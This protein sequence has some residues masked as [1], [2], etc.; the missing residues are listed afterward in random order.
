MPFLNNTK[1]K[2]NIDPKSKH[3]QGLREGDIVR[4]QYTDSNSLIYT[5][6]V[7]MSTGVEKVVDDEGVSRDSSYFIGMLLDGDAPQSGQV[8]DFV[9]MTNL[10]DS[11]R[12]GALYMTASDSGAPYMSVI[13]KLGTERSML[14]PHYYSTNAEATKNAY[15]A[16]LKEVASASYSNYSNGAYRVLRL[17]KTFA[18]TENPSVKGVFTDTLIPGD[19][20][21]I[22]L[23]VRAS[24]VGEATISTYQSSGSNTQSK[25]V[26]VTTDWTY[27]CLLYRCAENHIDTRTISITMPSDV[28]ADSWMEV[29]ELNVIKRSDVSSFIDA[30]KSRLGRIDGIVDPTFGT[31]IGYGL[32]SKNLYA[33]GDVSVAGTLTAGDENGSASTFYAGKIKKNVLRNS[34]SPNVSNMTVI[35]DIKSPTGVGQILKITKGASTPIL[36][37]R[38]AAWA[39]KH[40]HKLLTF[41]VWVYG[42]ETSTVTI[43]AKDQGEASVF[44]ID[45]GWNRC[46]MTFELVNASTDIAILF[47]STYSIAI[48]SPQLEI[49]DHATLY[50]PTDAV[51]ADESNEAYGMWACRGGIGGTIQNPLLS[52]ESDGSLRSRDGNF[53]ILADGSAYFKGTV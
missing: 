51:L 32:Y 8:L 53:Y 40:L 30:E 21:M 41:S 23:K 19:T 11:D 12:S 52:L 4:R 17:T 14:L 49:G 43:T 35:T 20:I 18:S 3:T 44:D 31:L 46:S 10:F 1:Y 48:T 42:Y 50:Q 26:A 47:S 15:Q 16:D 37:C 24:A 36:T 38:E 13:D 2:I 27:V 7:V 33:T 28:E 45:P 25:T 29:G 22:S 6:M 34:L 39:T 9:R 5:L